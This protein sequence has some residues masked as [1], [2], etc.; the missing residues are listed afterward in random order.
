[1]IVTW[2]RGVFLGV[3]VKVRFQPQQ[4]FAQPFNLGIGID[5]AGG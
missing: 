5:K 3:N 1:M 2:Q 4:F